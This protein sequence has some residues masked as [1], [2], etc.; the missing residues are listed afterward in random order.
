MTPFGKFPATSTRELAAEA[1]RLAL[2]DG[3]TAPEQVDSVFFANAMGGLMTGQEMI[4]G[5]VWLRDTGLLGTPI[6]NV[7]NA[8]ASASSAVHLAVAAVASGAAEIALAVGA[9]KLTH[10]DKTRAFEAMGTA[11][12]L[13][14]LDELK[15]ALYGGDPSP[16]GDRSFFMD[17]YAD[18]ARRFMERSG[19]TVRDF[20]Q[21]AVKSHAHAAHNPRAQYREP[22]TIEQ[23]LASREISTP[24]TLL[25]CSPIGDGAAAVVVCGEDVARRLGSPLVRI[26][27]SALV[28]G[29]DVPGETAV[30]RA[31]RI[32]YDRS[33]VSPGDVDVV[34]LH[35]AAAPAELILYE[36]LGLCAPGDASKL[37][38][39]GQTTLGGRV[40]VN[41][42]GGLISKG[43]PVG[44]TGCAQ[45]VELTEQ[46]RGQ[47]GARQTD[48][49]RVALAENGG[50]HLGPD[51]AAV[52]VTV[53]TRD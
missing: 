34:E 24:L 23:V 46:L 27:A 7:E 32:A 48:N 33:G 3:A 9:E 14:R 21:V 31:A 26:R 43:H 4:R 16:A 52:C 51:P 29:R 30:Q 12:D 17:V 39:S 22:V 13:E 53:L 35:D 40:P 11:V 25:M 45:L 20:A 8:C 44:A 10:P 41:P 2:A 19:A 42:S 50:G 36:E 47:S 5:Q 38:D 37:L 6:I 15:A 49:P 18:M 1:V 28:S